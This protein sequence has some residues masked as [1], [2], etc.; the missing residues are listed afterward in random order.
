VGDNR[1]RHYVGAFQLTALHE[2]VRAARPSRAAYDPFAV[3]AERI[4]VDL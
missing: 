4:G 2:Q 3:A 1:A